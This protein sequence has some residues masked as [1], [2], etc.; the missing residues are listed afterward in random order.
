MYKSASDDISNADSAQIVC[1]Y[2]GHDDICTIVLHKITQ[3]WV[4]AI[5]RKKSPLCILTIK[6][7]MLPYL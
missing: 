4:R 7:T 5:Q 3:Q 6:S 1:S 2:R